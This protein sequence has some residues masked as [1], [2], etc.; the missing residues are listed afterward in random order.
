MATG[1]EKVVASSPEVDAGDVFTHPTKHVVQAVAF[2]PGRSHWVVVDPSVRPDFEGLAK[3]D[4]GDFNVVNRD[5]ADSTWLAA[6]Q[7]DDGPVRYYAWDRAARKGTF[8]FSHQ[9]KLEGLKLA[10][11]KPVVIKSRDGLSLEFLPHLARRRL[12]EK[13]ARWSCWSTAAPGGATIGASTRWRS[14]WRTGATP[15]SR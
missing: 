15:A 10:A 5:K 2:A 14:G 8:L 7:H 3:L 6:F 13:P 9:P 1:A 4:G 11:M 12:P